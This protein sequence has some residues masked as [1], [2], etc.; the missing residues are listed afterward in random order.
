[1]GM[2]S[3]KGSGV[4]REELEYKDWRLTRS[5]REKMRT[6]EKQGIRLNQ[7]DSAS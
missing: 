1:M 2:L 6:Y 5:G 7:S 3:V 4:R